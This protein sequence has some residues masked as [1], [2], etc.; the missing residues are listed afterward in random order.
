MRYPSVAKAWPPQFKPDS[1][2]YS[3]TQIPFL[4]KILPWMVAERRSLTF[5]ATRLRM[6]PLASG[7]KSGKVAM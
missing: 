6:R 2:R 5:S 1:M 4:A 3:E 7:K